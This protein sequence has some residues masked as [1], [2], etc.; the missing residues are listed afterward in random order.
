MSDEYTVELR[1]GSPLRFYTDNPN[2]AYL[3]ATRLRVDDVLSYLDAGTPVDE[4]LEDFPQLS[5]EDVETCRRFRAHLD[6]NTETLKVRL[7]A[8]RR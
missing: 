6:A 1:F 2:T 4:L 3:Q 8:P 5:Q 7:H